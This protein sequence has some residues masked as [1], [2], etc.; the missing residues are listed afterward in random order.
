M[1]TSAVVKITKRK[2][3][4]PTVLAGKLRRIVG[5]KRELYICN[6]ICSYIDK[7]PSVS[8]KRIGIREL[9]FFTTF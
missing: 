1:I 6:I 3:K 2:E 4:I 8:G 9:A 5:L 7:C